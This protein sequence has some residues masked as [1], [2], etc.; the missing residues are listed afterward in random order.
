MKNL[1]L[2]KEDLSLIT[3]KEGLLKLLKSKKINVKKV[4]KT[5]KYEKELDKLQIELLKLQGDIVKNNKRVVVIFEGRDAAGKGGTIRR[6]IE[7]LNPRSNRVVALAKPTDKERGQW[8]FQRYIKQLPD[9]GE[10]VFFDRSWY[11]RAVVEPVNGFCDETQY[12]LFLSQ[13]VEFENMIKDSGITLI[14]FWLDTSKDEQAQRFED[15]LNSPLKQWKISPID[16]NAQKLWDVYTQYRDDMFRNTHSKNNPWII[17]QA[18]NKKSAR[19]ESI[20]YVLNLFDYNKKNKKLKFKPDSEI[21]KKYN[22]K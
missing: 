21:V 15:R 12:K 3:S 22:N 8:Y 7:H 16:K 5:L 9:A 1:N 2:T 17:V 10:L 14:K 4:L 6:F 19:L 18:D 20:R 13:V 11:N